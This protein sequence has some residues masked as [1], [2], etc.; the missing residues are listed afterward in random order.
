MTEREVKPN[1]KSS[2]FS[3]SFLPFGD[4]RKQNTNQQNTSGKN[5]RKETM[6]Q[7]VYDPVAV[8]FQLKCNLERTGELLTADMFLCHFLTYFDRLE[9]IVVCVCIS[10][11]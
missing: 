5:A 10:G 3:P 11:L 2:T 4:K 9:P 8:A 7:S 6:V 1:K